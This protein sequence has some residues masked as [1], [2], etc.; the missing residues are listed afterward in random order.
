MGK[1]DDV[2]WPP[3]TVVIFFSAD[4]NVASAQFWPHFAL[5]GSD[6]LKAL[7]SESLKLLTLKILTLNPLNH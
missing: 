7:N 6:P 4:K 1:G 5:A 2:E 3:R